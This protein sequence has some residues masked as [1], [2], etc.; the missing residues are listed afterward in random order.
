MDRCGR[1]EQI[2]ELLTSDMM[3]PCSTLFFLF[4]LF[5]LIVIFYHIL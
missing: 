1:P 4:F 5:L 2:D 3:P